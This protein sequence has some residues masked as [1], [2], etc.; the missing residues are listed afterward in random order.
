MQFYIIYAV[1]QEKGENL[2]G[3]TLRIVLII[4][5]ILM[6]FY[7]K[8]KIRDEQVKLNDGRFWIFLSIFFML[9]SIF[10]QII[11]WIGSLVGIISPI[12]LVFL[13]VIFLLLIKLFLASIKL[14]RAE[15]RIDELAQ[16]I[17]IANKHFNNGESSYNTDE[18]SGDIK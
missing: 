14:S 8:K 3:V 1:V 12:N 10:P 17:A 5:S 11:Y 4:S 2:M 18:G 16:E 9:I 7:V 13:I 15:T 6:F